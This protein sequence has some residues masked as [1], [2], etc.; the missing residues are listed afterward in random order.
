MVACPSVLREGVRSYTVNAADPHLQTL[1]ADAVCYLDMPG[2]TDR[3]LRLAAKHLVAALRS[4]PA[5][6]LQ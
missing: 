3:A 2:G 6:R 1:Y 5:F 4:N